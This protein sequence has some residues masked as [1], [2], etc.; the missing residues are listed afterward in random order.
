MI[1]NRLWVKLLQT[2]VN[3]NLKKNIFDLWQ[4][5]AYSEKAKEK[6]YGV[7]NKTVQIPDLMLNQDDFSEMAMSLALYEHR[8]SEKVLETAKAQLNTP[9]KIERFEFL[10]PALSSDVAVRDAF[11]DLGVSSMNF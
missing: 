11:F 3:P 6:L 9:D 7:W 8:L 2:D 10:R 4:G 1:E 5:I